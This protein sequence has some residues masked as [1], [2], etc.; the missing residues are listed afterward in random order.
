[1]T[2]GPLD[3]YR[4][5]VEK[6]Y[7][8]T[9]AGRLIWRGYPGAGYMVDVGDNVVHIHELESNEV[10]GGFDIYVSIENSILVEIE[11]FRDTDISQTKPDVP[12]FGTYYE[13][14]YALYSQIQRKIS[15]ADEILSGLLSELD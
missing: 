4:Q 7:K 12:G 3:K 11:G 15:G 1:M 9:N 8:Q 14:M 2:H 10:A 13:L 6:L 5:L